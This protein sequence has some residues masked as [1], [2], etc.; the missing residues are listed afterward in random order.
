MLEP[1][2]VQALPRTPAAAPKRTNIPTAFLRPVGTQLTD[3]VFCRG[4]KAAE[5]L[6]IGHGPGDEGGGLLTRD[7]RLEGPKGRGALDG[8]HTPIVLEVLIQCRL[9]HPP[10]RV[11][12]SAYSSYAMPTCLGVRVQNIL[13]VPGLRLN[14]NP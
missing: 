5:C 8:V 14:R 12:L 4:D 6:E 13:E 3:G 7:A 2:L 9:R 11:C 1:V 10:S